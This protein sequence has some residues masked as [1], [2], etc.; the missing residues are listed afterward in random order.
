MESYLSLGSPSM[1]YQGMEGGYETPLYKATKRCRN[2]DHFVMLA[3][4]GQATLAVCDPELELKR[5][6]LLATQQ[7]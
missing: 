5:S 4:V 1:M 7:S 2:G 6:R 3:K